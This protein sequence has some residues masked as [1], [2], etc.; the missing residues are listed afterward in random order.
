MK[1]KKLVS[2]VASIS[3]LASF[4]VAQ[5]QADGTL[6][7]SYGFQTD[8]SGNKFIKWDGNQY[9]TTP[10]T[11][12]NVSVINL[13]DKLGVFNHPTNGYYKTYANNL[14]ACILG[15]ETLNG[16]SNTTEEG[17]WLGASAGEAIITPENQ[18]FLQRRI[19]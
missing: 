3:M 1:F 12:A 13:G 6:L 19:I 17:Y 4:G 11:I 15:Y 16:N 10:N 14:R 18:V 5:V 9:T 7:T 2:L 8:L